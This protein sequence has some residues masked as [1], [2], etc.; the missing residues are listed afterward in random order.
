M[1]TSRFNA[2]ILMAFC[3]IAASACVENER[4]VLIVPQQET[5]S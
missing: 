5:G 2:L 1:T 4:A 3:A